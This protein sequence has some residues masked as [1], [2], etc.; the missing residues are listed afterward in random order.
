MWIFVQKIFFS[1]FFVGKVSEKLVERDRT[2]L[3]GEGW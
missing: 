1:K 2:K 3:I